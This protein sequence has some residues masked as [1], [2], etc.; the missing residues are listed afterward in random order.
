MISE[1]LNARGV[2]EERVKKAFD[3]E[4]FR[5]INAAV[6]KVVL[7]MASLEKHGVMSREDIEDAVIASFEQSE[8]LMYGLSEHEL[9]KVVDWEI[10]NDR[11]RRESR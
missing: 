3:A 2:Y 11:A 8:Y 1:R 10:N 7:V 9:M 4:A 5:V 6:R